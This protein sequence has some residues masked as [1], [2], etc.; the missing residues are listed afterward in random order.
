MH[1]KRRI[2]VAVVSVTV[3]LA[4]LVNGIVQD[5]QPVVPTSPSQS[6][7]AGEQKPVEGSARAALSA[8]EVKGRAPKTGYSRSQFGRGWQELAECDMRNYILGRD[9]TQVQTISAVDCTVLKG[10]L[11]DPYTGKVIAFVRGPATSDDVQ[12]DH[13]VALSDAWQKGAQ[14]I[15]AAK[16]YQFANDPLNLLAVDG[17]T[18]NQKGD[19]DAAT[20]LPPHKPYRCQYVARQIAVKSKYALWVTVSEHEAMKR[21]LAGCP[22]QALPLISERAPV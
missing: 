12:V 15:T 14:N 22:T 16:R 1:R 2:A 17:P 4:A 13:V 19:G 7:A 5:R 11:Q 8:L 20:W 6:P 21:V 9:M 3:V 18:N 10:S